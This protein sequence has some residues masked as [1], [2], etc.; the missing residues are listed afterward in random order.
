MFVLRLGG[1]APSLERGQASL[2]DFDDLLLGPVVPVIREGSD[3]GVGELNV[4][5]KKCLPI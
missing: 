1:D 2:G 5:L 3:A 4:D